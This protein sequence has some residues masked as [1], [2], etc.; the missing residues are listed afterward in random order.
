MQTAR[1]YIT[2]VLKINPGDIARNIQRHDIHRIARSDDIELIFVFFSATCKN[3]TQ[4]YDYVCKVCEFPY[5]NDEYT[6][7]V[8]IIIF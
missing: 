1:V 6:N 5:G 4:T 2:H 3:K 7:E 8:D